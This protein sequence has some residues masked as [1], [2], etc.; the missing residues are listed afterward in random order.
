MT[1][2]NESAAAP[3]PLAFGAGLQ[4]HLLTVGHD[5]E[6]LQALL[7][8]SYETLQGGFFATLQQLHSLHDDGNLGHASWTEARSHLAGAVKALQF[9]DMAT[10]LIAH[11]GQRLRCCVDELAHQVF[12]ADSEFDAP[13]QSAPLCP[14]PV[15]QSE[16]N[17]G[18]VELF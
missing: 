2:G 18:W 7:D 9:H 3:L 16:M 8:T 17:T 13:A 11:T 12:A 4:D 15:T 1:S 14:N 10:Q 5:L 6:R